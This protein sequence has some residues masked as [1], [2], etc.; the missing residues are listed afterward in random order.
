MIGL[1]GHH[2]MASAEYE[3][4]MGMGACLQWGPGA[5]TLVGSSRVSSSHVAEWDFESQIVVALHNCGTCF[6]A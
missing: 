6:T 4:T 3:L 2:T 5:K 1:M